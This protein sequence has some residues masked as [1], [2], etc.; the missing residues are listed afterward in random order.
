[1]DR[2]NIPGPISAL[3]NQTRELEV[4]LT[5]RAIKTEMISYKLVDCDDPMSRK[6]NRNA[7]QESKNTI[8][9]SQA[10]VEPK[11]P[12]QRGQHIETNAQMEDSDEHSPTRRKLYFKDALTKKNEDR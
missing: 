7:T 4:A 3:K 10:D 5:T 6:R 11:T 9:A 8:Q 1:M 2:M 12:A